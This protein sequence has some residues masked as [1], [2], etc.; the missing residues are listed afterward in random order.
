MELING[1]KSKTININLTAGES[2]FYL[3][4]SENLGLPEGAKIIAI[5]TRTHDSS[6][7]SYQKKQLASTT[8]YNAAFLS[9]L[10]TNNNDILNG[11]QLNR[12]ANKAVFIEPIKASGIDWNNSYID[13]ANAAV[14]AI[15]DSIIEIVVFY[16]EGDYTHTVNNQVLF[17][18]GFQQI[19][20]RQTAYQVAVE[21]NRDEYPIA[22]RNI[23]IPNNA[24]IVGINTTRS[25]TPQKGTAQDDSS[26][27]S[28]Y[29]TLKKGTE[30]LLDNFP[31]ALVGYSTLLFP[32]LDYFPIEPV[33]AG[34]ID[35][36]A[37]EIKI[38]NTNELTDDMVA[39]IDIVWCMPS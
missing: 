24:Y 26:Y 30:I 20:V 10:D 1:L 37:S 29:L 3:Q 9:M 8:V 35:W 16:I 7:N 15:V 18:T 21:T 36:K 13:V 6:I 17:R 25:L 23:G 14:S 11:Y 28:S 39:Q 38:K 22:D 4:Q 12:T 27:S 32:G 31:I 2:K 33:L 19:G 5:A 34:D